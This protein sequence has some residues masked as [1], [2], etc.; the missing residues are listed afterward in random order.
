MNDVDLSK[1]TNPAPK[2]T[3]WTVAGILTGGGFSVVNLVFSITGLIFFFSLISA[4]FSY[5]TNQGNPQKIAD[6][7]GRIYNS[8]LGLGVVFASFLIVRLFATMFGFEKLLPF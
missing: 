2:I 4:A 3:D 8:A 5:V 7:T 6:S 1:F